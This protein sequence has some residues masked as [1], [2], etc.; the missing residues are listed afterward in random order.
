MF[1]DSYANGVQY[2][3]IPQ[4]TGF[5]ALGRSDWELFTESLAHFFFGWDSGGPARRYAEFLR[6]CVDQEEGLRFFDDMM[7]IDL[8]DVLPRLEVPAVVVQHRRASVPDMASA[9]LLASRLPD[10]DLVLLDGFWNDPQ[11]DL[12]RIDAALSRLLGQEPASEPPATYDLKSSTRRTSGPVT[13]L[14]TDIE[15]STALTQR[16]GDVR[17]REVFREHERITR[18]ALARHGGS[19]VKTMGDG[20]MASFGSAT[21]ALECAIW[22]QRMFEDHNAGN[23]EPIH[24]RIGLNAG[25]PIAE[26]RDLFGTPVIVASRIAAKPKGREILVSNVVRELVAGRGFLFNDRGDT[27]LRGF[28][29]PVRVFEVAWMRGAE[30]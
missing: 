5:L 12:E 7:A 13:I 29:D 30:G 27:P 2:K 24:I 23:A 14:F 21:S 15:E 18:E 10:A 28:E 3:E 9:R 19:E 4:V 16:L 26:D 25:E 6:E 17:A 8:T 22:M 20:F 11:D 1:L